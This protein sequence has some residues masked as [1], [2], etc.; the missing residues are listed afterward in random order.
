MGNGAFWD[1]QQQQQQKKEQK[2]SYPHKN[3]QDFTMFYIS[4]V[5]P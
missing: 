4:R 1:N 5:N 3:F 2:I